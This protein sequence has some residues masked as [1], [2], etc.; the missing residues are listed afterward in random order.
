MTRTAI[1]LPFCALALWVA[2]SL[3]DLEVFYVMAAALVAVEA[4]SLVLALLAGGGLRADREVPARIRQ[5][6]TVP[7]RLTVRCERGTGLSSFLVRDRIPAADGAEPAAWI[8]GLGRGDAVAVEF[9]IPATLRGEH[10]LGPVEVLCQ[11]PLGLFRRRRRL[12]CPG[13]LLVQPRWE[14]VDFPPLPG[15]R[16]SALVSGEHASVEGGGEEFFGI[17]EYRRG[18][19]LRHVHWRTTARNGKLTV[20]QFENE[21]H[22]DIALYVDTAAPNDEEDASAL[23]RCAAVAASLG[24]QA[25]SSNSRLV[26]AAAGGQR[27]HLIGGEAE[28]RILLRF[29][30]RLKPRPG[31]GPDAGLTEMLPLVTGRESVLAVLA[32]IDSQTA[33]VLSSLVH[34]GIATVIFFVEHESAPSFRRRWRWRRRVVPE[35]TEQEE[36]LTGLAGLGI[37]VVRVREEGSLNR[38][39]RAWLQ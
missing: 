13:K 6:E 18:D 29:L 10:D 38:A 8:S 23:D 33:A 20:R 9:E 15:R 28:R 14:P 5:G 17:R 31:T 27:L 26:C 19:S 7:I 12:A 1:L 22:P 37:P 11:D 32:S 36:L 2:G 35:A 3:V 30:A 34:R 25:L 4:V 39:V 21:A 24:L 16:R